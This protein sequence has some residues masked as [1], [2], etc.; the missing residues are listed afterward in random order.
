[1]RRRSPPERRTPFGPSGP[2]RR[3]A[4]QPVDDG[5]KARVALPLLAGAPADQLARRWVA[6]EVVALPE[7][8]RADSPRSRVTAPRVRLLQA[9]DQ[10]QQ[11][12]LAVPVAPDDAD[13]VAVG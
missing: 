9:R 3:P 7:Q 8:R 5:A 12:R 2:R 4:E 1:M 6:V 13:P 10:P 11:R